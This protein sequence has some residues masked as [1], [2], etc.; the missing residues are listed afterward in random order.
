MHARTP[1]APINC[2]YAVY[3]VHR[4]VSFLVQNVSRNSSSEIHVVRRKC[5]F[6]VHTVHVIY[7]KSL[8]FLSLCISSCLYVCLRFDQLPRIRAL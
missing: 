6:E 4:K 2:S 1:L 3:T 5:S 7:I 8:A